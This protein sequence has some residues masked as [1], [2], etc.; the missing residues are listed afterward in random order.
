MDYFH[1]MSDDVPPEPLEGFPPYVTPDEAIKWA[2]KEA[3]RRGARVQIFRP[4]DDRFE[5]QPWRVV[6]PPKSS[7]VDG[8]LA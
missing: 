1:L 4:R 5:S 6:G 8:S 2:E 7:S 3:Q